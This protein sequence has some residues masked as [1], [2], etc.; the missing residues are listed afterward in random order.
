[1]S[2]SNTSPLD[3]VKAILL[4]EWDPLRLGGSDPYA[5]DSYARQA[6]AMLEQRRSIQDLAAYL[7]EVASELTGTPDLAYQVSADT[8]ARLKG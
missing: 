7:H 6:Q 5:Y 3:R 2:E 8:A 1:M 4:K